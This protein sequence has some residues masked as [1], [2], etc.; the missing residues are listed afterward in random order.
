MTRVSRIFLTAAILAVPVSA[1]DDAKLAFFEKN[2]RPVLVE[3]CYSCHAAD[4][5]NIR[6]GL[7]LDSQQGWQTGGDSGPT[8]VP[9]KPQ[10]SLLLQALRHE[11]F[12]MPPDQKL[13]DDVIAD[14]ERWIADGAVDPRTGGAT[15]ERGTIDLA[16]GRMFWSFR[17]IHRPAV[18]TRQGEARPEPRVP[19]DAFRSNGSA[20]VSPSHTWP[21]TDIDRFIADGHAEHGLRPAADA[22]ASVVARRLYFGLIGLPPTADQLQAFEADYNEDADR[23]I[24]TLAD[25]LLA[26]RHFGE[27]WGRHWLDVA[28][29]AESSGGG[30][31]LMFPD[32]WRFRDYVIAS[33]NDDKPLN[34]LAREHIA[35]DLLPWSTPEQHDEQVTGVGYL[36]LGPTNY[37]LQDKEL[38]RMEVVDEQID[39]LGRTFLGLTLGC[40]RCHD[41]KFDPLPTTDYY[42]LAGIFRSTKTLVPGNV[43]GYV[44]TSL[45]SGVDADRLAEWQGTAFEL[46]KRIAI[47]KTQTGNSSLAGVKGIDPE[48]LP[49][50]VIDDAAAKFTGQWTDSTHSPP[51]VGAGYRH[52]GNDKAGKSVRFEVMLPE[53]GAY[54]VRLAHNASNS[55]CSSLPVRIEHAGGVATSTIDQRTTTEADG[56]FSDLGEYHFE[57]NE[58]AVVSINAEEAAGG[59]I[60]IDAVQFLPVR[61]DAT[62]TAESDAVDAERQRSLRAELAALEERLKKHVA[63]KPVIPTAMGVTDE[64]DPGDWHLHVRGGIRNLG[65]LVPRGFISVAS[66]P[67]DESGRAVPAKIPG[68]QSG[69]LELA[70]WVAS[71][72][73]P[74]TARVFVNRVWQHLIGEGLVRTPDN[75]GATGRRPTHPELL[76]YLAASFIEDDEWSVRKLIRRIVT[77]RVYRLSS[78]ARTDDAPGDPENLHLTRA[79]RRRL[80]AESLRDAI[81]QISGQLDLNTTGGLTIGKIATY[82]N[83]YQHER[84][85]ANMRSVYVPFFRNSMLETFEVFDIAN[86]NLVTGRRTTSTLPSQA[87]YMLNSPFV[88][89]QSEFA[90]QHFLATQSADPAAL[91][92][93]IEEA[94]RQ[95]LGHQPT[96]A[97]SQT[98]AQFVTSNGVDAP[99]TWAAV[100]QSLFASMDFRYLD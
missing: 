92:V 85:S 80:D 32:A 48:S 7:L 39:T 90:A 23:A 78:S 69:R 10:E 33:F 17:P 52:D 73:N 93:M 91:D 65:P 34:Q 74:L 14:F 45:K 1:A 4:A 100:F 62:A 47:L 67:L 94:Y 77:S 75:F 13:P 97:E 27:R 30:R 25:E 22:T 19:T 95:T 18:P 58:A 64:A 36:T 99:D 31:S 20:G 84:F 21:R 54:R 29:F 49:G 15:I 50:I 60:I 37:E 35:G 55:R 71:P 40:A 26:S 46:M 51:Y 2:I 79:F 28:R 98:L 38:L 3:H 89:E 81:L 66:P 83:G 96:A 53:T 6:G 57:A 43:S 76:D 5:K 59:Y 72:Q 87:L 42:A 12:E 11:S 24:A 16:E 61:E 82:D 56:V 86:A 41:H 63:S 88:L 44:T 70:E 68:D 9:G 8:I